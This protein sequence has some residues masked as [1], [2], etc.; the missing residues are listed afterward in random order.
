MYCFFSIIFSR[1]EFNCCFIRKQYYQND[2]IYR[3][4]S[5][6]QMYYL[7]AYKELSIYKYSKFYLLFCV[8]KG[9]SINR[10]LSRPHVVLTGENL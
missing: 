10:I 9:L 8:N 5:I 4:S 1:F 2:N 3:L 6:V 7:S